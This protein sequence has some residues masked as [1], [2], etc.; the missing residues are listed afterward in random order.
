[1]WFYISLCFI[2]LFAYFGIEFAKWRCSLPDD[3]AYNQK[4]SII[5]QS[6]I[7]KDD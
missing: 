1:M 6:I 2:Y 3:H 4:K 7:K 5:D